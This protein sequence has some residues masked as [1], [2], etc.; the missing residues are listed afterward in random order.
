M[1]VDSNLPNPWLESLT[2]SK[3]ESHKTNGGSAP[4]HAHVEDHGA[5]DLPADSFAIKSPA[6]DTPRADKI[7]A[8]QRAIAGGAYDVS[9]ENIADAMIRDWQA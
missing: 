3:T 8:L 5:E 1:R 2:S 7:E 6:L 4:S 9:A